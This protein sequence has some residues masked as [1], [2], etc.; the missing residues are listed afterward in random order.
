MEPT[1]WA[2]G[3]LHVFEYACSRGADRDELSRR[4]DLRGLSL[5]DPDARLPMRCYYNVIEA[6]AELTGDP[7]FGLSYID[8][9][10]PDAI[11]AIGFL[12]MTSATLGESIERILHYYRVLADGEKLTLEVEGARATVR[13]EPWGPRRPAHVHVCEMYAFDFLVLA[14]RMTGEPVPI[15]GFDV[16]HERHGGDA[17]YLHHF[18]RVPRFGAPENAWS[19]PAAVLARPMQKAD[20]ALSRF[21][22]GYVEKLGRTLPDE[23]FSASVRR[24]IEERLVDGELSPASLARSLR[25]SPRT[26][27]RRLAS[28]HTNV[29]AIESEV[30]RERARAFL[31]ANLA[32]GEISY[33]LGFS[34]PRAFHRAFRRWTGRTPQQY[35]SRPR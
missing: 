31:D 15:L 12:A 34:E 16:R 14:G 24:A 29:S 2:R 23:S 35:R 33:L 30:R 6:G 7:Y 5:R 18:G 21:F 28:E 22:E 32:I 11:G 4:M 3:P 8:G 19:F 13:F 10:T 9:I 20:P 17:P 25:M 1:G 26:L 27:Q